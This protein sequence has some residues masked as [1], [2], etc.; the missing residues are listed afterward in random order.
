MRRFNI[1]RLLENS[2]RSDVRGYNIYT[3]GKQNMDRPSKEN[4]LLKQWD[5]AALGL[6]GMAAIGHQID[7]TDLI[8][9]IISLNGTPL[10]FE[11]RRNRWTPAYMDTYYR[12]QPFGEYSKSGLIAIRER[13]CFTED[14]TFISHLTLFNDGRESVTLELSLSVPFEKISDGVYSAY[15]KIMPGSLCKEMFLKGFACAKTNVGEKA[16]FTIPAL[17]KVELRYGFSFSAESSSAASE[18]LNYAL[19]FNDPFSEAEERFNK[20][21]EQHAPALNIDDYDLLK[22]YYYRFFVIKS[23]IHEPS[24]VLYESDYKGQCVYES[25]FGSWFGAPVGLPIPLQIEDMKWMKDT[26]ALRSHIAN[27]CE[28]H[29]IT[30]G[31]IQFTPMAIW[32]TFIQTGDRNIISDSYEKVKKYVLKKAPDPEVKLPITIGSWVTG[33]EYQPSFYQ[34][35]EEKWD[36]RYDSEG[37]K[38]GFH[39]RKLY[40]LDECV[41]FAANLRACE[42]MAR[43]LGMTE[44][45]LFFGARTEEALGQMKKLFWNEEKKFFF[46]FDPEIGKQCDEA[47]GYD[48]F[49]PM[50]FSLFGQDY[51]SVFEKLRK[52]ERFDCGFALTSVAKDCPM[53][54]FD[55]CITGPTAASLS[56]PHSY[57]CSWNGPI[58]PYSISLVLE[59]LGNAS[60]SDPSLSLIF[61]RLFIEYTDLHFDCGDRST[62]CICEHYRPTDAISF[63]PFTEYF[64]SEWINLFISYYLGIRVSNGEISFAPLTD[65]DFVLDDVIINGKAYRFSQEKRN[66]EI[67]RNVTEL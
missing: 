9:P 6:H 27:W 28:G 40:R 51:Y 65:K 50:M 1:N 37:T 16:V 58:W 45:A 31:Y 52:D 41:M 21:M 55:N 54:W 38:N 23:S 66:G 17:S 29:G 63:S 49:M 22:I 62:P 44:D 42:K 61:N 39:L 12:C 18:A 15:A 25:P 32:E 46:D 7:K 19:A 5:D 59:A 3:C 35:T 13:K 2:R 20:W 43:L 57:G 30:Q 53:Y 47:Y 24:A 11:L 14:D 36:W 64:H 10:R 48:G 33:A 4:P 34:Y 56:E 8:L 60:Y 26:S 67:N